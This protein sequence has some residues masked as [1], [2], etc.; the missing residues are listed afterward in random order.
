MTKNMEREFTPGPMVAC[1]KVIFKM[2]NNMEKVYIDRTMDKRSM[3]YGKKERRL[4]SLTANKSLWKSK[5][6]KN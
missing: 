1:T 3:V 6:T 4:R 5:K 2:E